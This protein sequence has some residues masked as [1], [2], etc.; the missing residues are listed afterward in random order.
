MVN[1]NIWWCVHGLWRS[2]KSYQKKEFKPLIIIFVIWQVL[3][4]LA[5]MLFHRYFSHHSFKMSRPVQFLF[6]AAGL[7][8]NQRGGLWWSS[9]HRSHHFACDTVNDPHSPAHTGFYYS[10]VGWTFYM[11]NTP[12][13]FNK[14]REFQPFPELVFL[15]VFASNF[16]ALFL[17]SMRDII[18]RKM[19][20]LYYIGSWFCVH[21]AFFTNS[22]SHDWS[23]GESDGCVSNDTWWV[24]VLNGGEGF[25]RP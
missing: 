3:I 12:I 25:H 13:M 22:I 16:L 9:H 10:H 20:K 1:F 4:V 23:L 17:K 6:A 24:G 2:E 8:A 14:I 18:P 15:D 21:F 11:Q 5:H 19:V 7:L